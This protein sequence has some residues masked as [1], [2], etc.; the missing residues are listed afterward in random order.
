MTGQLLMTAFI[1]GLA[2]GVTPG[3]VLAAVFTEILQSGLRGAMAIVAWALL[4][5]ICHAFQI[6]QNASDR[7]VPDLGTRKAVANVDFGVA[8]IDRDD[9]LGERGRGRRR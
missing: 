2:G 9:V 5:E 1:L 6:E 7:A 3:P 4:V 8:P